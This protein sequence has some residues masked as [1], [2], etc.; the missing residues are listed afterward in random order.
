MEKKLRWGLLS[1]AAI[2]RDI[3]PAI[4]GSKRNEIVAV[5]SRTV[6]KAQAFAKE[7][8]IPRFFG[9]YGALVDDPQ[10][11][12]IY[13]PLPN[14]LHAPWTIRC[15]EAGKHVLVEKPIALTTHD[16]DEIIRATGDQHVVVTE[17][18][19]YR[20]N[21]QTLKVI[22]LVKSGAIGQVKIMRGIFNHVF[23]RAD[24]F[25]WDP[26][27]GGGSLWDLGCYPIS[28]IRMITGNKPEKVSG[29]QVLA[30]SRVDVS[31]AG[32]MRYT[33]NILAQF[34]CSFTLPRYT[35]IEIH[36]T[37]GSLLLSTPFTPKE[38][39]FITLRQGKQYQTFDFKTRDLY[40]GEVE[41]I[42]DAILNGTE[43]RVSLQESRDVVE[44]I[45]E[46]YQSTRN[47][48]L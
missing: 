17:A 21:P 38:R 45:N 14:H 30:S 24:N 46:L 35:S 25:R 19:M 32:Q 1:T 8:K 15:A 23:E 4:R 28:Y 9:S 3:I 37:E 31:F 2:N 6:E 39:T 29:Y 36:G 10:I 48:I 13:N 40:S 11:D 41:D 42:T 12:V 27:C 26:D 22:D 47:T 43:P 7:W 34:S 18:F 33:Q 16:I 44:T 5:A 20:H